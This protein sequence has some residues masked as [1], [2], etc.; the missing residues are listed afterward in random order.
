M[1]P[2]VVQNSAW[3]N[4]HDVSFLA[5]VKKKNADQERAGVNDT[6]RQQQR[7]VAGEESAANTLRANLGLRS[8]KLGQLRSRG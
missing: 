1:R 2:I 6:G 4:V 5:D 3:T 8:V 7:T